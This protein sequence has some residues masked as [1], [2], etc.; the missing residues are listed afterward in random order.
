MLFQ[1]KIVFLHELKWGSNYCEKISSTAWLVALVQAHGIVLCSVILYIITKLMRKTTEG[2]KYPMNI[3]NCKMS[4]D[5]ILV[6]KCYQL[7][8]SF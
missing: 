5:S 1:C 8:R 3:F 6:R 4:H 2:V 7:R